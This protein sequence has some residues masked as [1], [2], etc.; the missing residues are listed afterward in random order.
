MILVGSVFNLDTKIIDEREF[1]EKFKEKN[2]QG[3]HK[4]VS[5]YDNYIAPTMRARGYKFVNYA[6]RTVTFTFGQ[7][8]FSRRRWYK[9]GKCRIPVDEKLGLEK[10]IA[11]SKELLYQI[12]KLATMLPYRKVVEVIE[13]MY[14]VYITKDT[15]LK[16]IKLASQLL[17][18]KENYRFYSDEVP[19]KK[20]EAP[21]IY[22]EGDGV[23]I[24][25][26][27]REKE[28]HYKELSH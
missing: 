14:Q 24:N 17:N 1:V 26:S 25:V 3:F 19:V 2:L 4:F 11:Y 27:V 21:V 13:L 9:N 6:E 20:I 5:D 23:W 8:T 16:A 7:V 28:Q 12:T 10:R 18:E 15:V 22:L